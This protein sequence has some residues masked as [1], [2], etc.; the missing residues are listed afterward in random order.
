V[1]RICPLDL[2]SRNRHPIRRFRSRVKSGAYRRSC[3]RRP[4]GTRSECGGAR[5]ADPCFRHRRRNYRLSAGRSA[6][7]WNAAVVEL[8]CVHRPTGHTWPEVLCCLSR[9][10]SRI[11]HSSA[12]MQ[13]TQYGGFAAFLALNSSAATRHVAA[14][15]LPESAVPASIETTELAYL[16]GFSETGATG[17]EPATSGVTGR[18]GHDDVRRRTP[19]NGAICRYFST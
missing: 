15:L 5:S 7:E 11:S 17:L 8:R 9:G 14:R 4:Q 6:R 12:P 2:S 19:P 10:G 16:Q 3:P 1:S 18:V 13:T